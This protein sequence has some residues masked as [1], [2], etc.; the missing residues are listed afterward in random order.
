MNRLTFRGKEKFGV[1]G[2]NEANQDKKLYACVLKL[3]DYED[4]NLSPNDI[5]ELKEENDQLKKELAELKLGE[6]PYKTK[7]DINKLF[8]TKAE[9][10]HYLRHANITRT[11]Q[12]PFLTWEE[13]LKK[14]KFHFI[15]KFGNWYD[16]L[17]SDN[18]LLLRQ[19]DTFNVYRG[20][21]TEENF[22]KAYDECVRLFK[23]ELLK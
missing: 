15:D 18:R 11:E 21:L 14:E 10:E 3:V 23:G 16:L 5:L 1:V 9:A 20:D 22:Y 4:T 19:E 13:F 17:I 2:M 8:K 6:M 7:I 12:L